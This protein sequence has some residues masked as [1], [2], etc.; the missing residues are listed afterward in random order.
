MNDAKLRTTA[1]DNKSYKFIEECVDKKMRKQSI[2]QVNS[3]MIECK[4]TSASISE[5]ESELPLVSI[6]KNNSMEIVQHEKY[7]DNKTM[8]RMDEKVQKNLKVF[9]F[10][11]L[12]FLSYFTL[13]LSLFFNLLRF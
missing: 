10:Y 12:F 5:Y 8:P 2:S 11:Y 1:N 9:S 3:E 13:S 7:T 4:Y 6:V